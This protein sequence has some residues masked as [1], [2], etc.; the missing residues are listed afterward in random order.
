MSLR[1]ALEIL[2]GQGIMPS[3]QGHG[4]KV[5][6][7]APSPEGAAPGAE[8]DWELWLEKNKE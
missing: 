2:A 3:I 1:R 6:D 7:Q 8:K 4:V 5:Q